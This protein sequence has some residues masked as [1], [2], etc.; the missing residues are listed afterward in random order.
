MA[1]LLYGSL[2]NSNPF[3]NGII[4]SS[5]GFAF[6]E[7]NPEREKSSLP[8][9][10]TQYVSV[11]LSPFGVYLFSLDVIKFLFNKYGG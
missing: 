10:G 2:I 6:N 8:W 3:Q 9:N 5:M 7:K 11:R 4:P 1:P